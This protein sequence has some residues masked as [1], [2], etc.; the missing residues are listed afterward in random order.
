[1]K[2]EDIS[3]LAQ[4][5]KTIREGV[6]KLEKAQKDKDSERVLAIKKEIEKFQKKVDE[7]L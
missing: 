6:E 7:L 4:L 1:M 2:K 3:T 5:L